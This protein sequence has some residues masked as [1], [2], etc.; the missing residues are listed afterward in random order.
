[1]KNKAVLGIAAG[2]GITII[3]SYVGYAHMQAQEAERADQLMRAEARCDGFK[4]DVQGIFQSLFRTAAGY[5]IGGEYD[6]PENWADLTSPEGYYDRL[7]EP[8]SE[9]ND[10]SKG[11]QN[12]ARA[13]LPYARDLWIARND[14]ATWRI[15]REVCVQ[16]E[17]KR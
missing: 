10:Y 15:G 6:T 2:L 16:V 14:D 4:R 8:F 9:I 3:G 7:I 17:M 1:M 5:E 13:M 12:I 11:A